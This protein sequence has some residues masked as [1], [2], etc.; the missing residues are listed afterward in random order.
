M[1]ELLPTNVW[2]LAQKITR[3]VRQH[4]GDK[5]VHR[6]INFPQMPLQL[7]CHIDSPARV[8]VDLRHEGLNV[9]TIEH[10]DLSGDLMREQE[11]SVFY[12]GTKVL[13]GRMWVRLQVVRKQDFH[14]L[15]SLL[16]QTS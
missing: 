14:R 5:N 13:H 7:L 4:L 1:P 16:L 15:S 9:L 3:K 10:L 6:P 11:S 2:K 12:N 8:A